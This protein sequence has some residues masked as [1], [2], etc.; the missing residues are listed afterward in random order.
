MPPENFGKKA[1]KKNGG[2]SSGGDNK[3]TI[4]HKNVMLQ[5]RKDATKYS[6]LGVSIGFIVKTRKPIKYLLVDVLASLGENGKYDV[7]KWEDLMGASVPFNVKK[8]EMTFATIGDEKKIVESA[9]LASNDTAELKG[10]NFKKVYSPKGTCYGFEI[11]CDDEMNFSFVGV[12]HMSVSDYN[13]M[14]TVNVDTKRGE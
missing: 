2:G 4:N 1:N 13:L 11:S 7:P 8:V 12:L 3:I 9:T 5:M 6:A 10:L 14:T